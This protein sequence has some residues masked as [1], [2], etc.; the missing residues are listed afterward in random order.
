MSWNDIDQTLFAAHLRDTLAAIDAALEQ[1]GHD[2]VVIAAGEAR[3]VFQDDQTYPFRPSPWFRWLMPGPPS[4]GSVVE[5]VPGEQPRLLFVAPEDFWH[6]PPTVPDEAWTGL[7]RLQTVRDAREIVS[8][9]KLSSGRRA[10]IGEE[11]P[12]GAGWESNPPELLARLVQARCLKSAWELSNLREATRIAV[13]G[14]LAAEQAFR[15]GAAEY[16]IHLAFLGAVRQDEAALPYPPIIALNEHGAVLHYQHREMQPPGRVLSLL[17]DAGASRRGY[18]SDITR[19]WASTPGLFATLVEGMHAVQMQ[20]CSQVVAGA[21]WRTLHLEAHRL[22]AQLLRDTDVLHMSPDAAL[23]SGVSAAFL[24]HGL[25][26]LLGLQ[27]HDV[28]GFQSAAD[29]APIPRPPGHPALR[30]TR[31]LEPGMVVTVEPGLYFVGSLLAALRSG[32]HAE[33][34]NWPLVERLSPYGGIRIEDNLAVTTGGAENLTRMAFA[35]AA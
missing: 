7:F 25:G 28:G 8:A 10:W 17:I 15:R 9:V 21:D 6:S 13:A 33:A 26:H 29:A 20:L 27:V 22:V 35:A 4:P 19:T 18:G 30:L 12:P 3:L 1:S 11:P 31:K 14:H 34:V 5:Y 16:D 32:A 24:P 23:E 2:G